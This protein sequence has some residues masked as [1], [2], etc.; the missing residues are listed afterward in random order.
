MKDKFPIPTIDELLGKLKVA[1]IFSKLDIRSEF[2]QI[3]IPPPHTHRENNI[4]THQ[5][6][7]EFLVMSFGLIIA[8]TTFQ[9]LMNEVFEEVCDHYFMIY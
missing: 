4:K 7:F 6:N 3:R 5:G 8:P 2:H 9:S 1:N